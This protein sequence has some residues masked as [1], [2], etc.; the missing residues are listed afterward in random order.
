[1]LEFERDF[2]FMRQLISVVMRSPCPFRFSEA[3]EDLAA[4]EKDYEEVSPF[5]N[6]QEQVQ[7]NYS[8]KRGSG[9]VASGAQGPASLRIAWTGG[10]ASVLFE[11]PRRG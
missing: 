2:R 5:E 11:R 8:S 4:L 3:R 10:Q 9:I 6:M 1:M 7:E